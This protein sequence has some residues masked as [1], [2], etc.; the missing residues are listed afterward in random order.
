MNYRSIQRSSASEQVMKEILNNI[1][2]GRLKPGERLPTEREF[3]KMF[4]VGRST[5]REAVSALA[6]I[7]YLEVVQGRGTFLKRD[8]KPGKP[9]RF[10]LS[11]IQ[12][13]ANIIDLVEVR[14]ILECNAV[15]LASRRAGPEDIQ[16]IEEALSEVKKTADNIKAFTRNDF[17]F[18]IAL[19]R[20]TG[21]AMILD[22]MEGI[23]KKIHK[24][25]GNFRNQV[26][27][28]TDTAVF[29]AEK[30]V[31][32]IKNGDGEGASAQMHKHLRLVTTEVR[33]MIPELTH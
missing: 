7:G 25:Y 6:V 31:E 32:C 11:D 19:A 9:A 15:K 14:E 21:N 4:K 20:A 5:V 2:K 24:A 27:F 8:V 16:R 3:S 26:L 29:T 28:Q 33:Q 12:M 30:I 23:I 1:T 17:A 10:D 13:A 22:M 18:H